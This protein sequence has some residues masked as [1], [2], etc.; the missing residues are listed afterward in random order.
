MLEDV[1]K[2]GKKGELV[3]VALGYW[4]NYLQPFRKAEAATERTL[5]SIRAEEEAEIRLKQEIK[6]KAIRLELALRTIG[7]FT[8]PKKAGEKDAIFGS[9]TRQEIVDAIYQQT[10]QELEKQNIQSPEIK[11]LG[12]FDVT[13]KLHPE[14]TGAFKVV[15]VKDR[16]PKGKK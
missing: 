3:T 12:T 4:R 15:V 6:D 7:K 14:V 16:N 2:L 11:T 10:G 1:Q 9:V 8:I 5:E 13:V